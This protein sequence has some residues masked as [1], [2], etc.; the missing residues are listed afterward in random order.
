LKS[1]KTSNLEPAAGGGF[2]ARSPIYRAFKLFFNAPASHPFL[3]LVCVVIAG[4]LEALS[5]GSLVPAVALVGGSNNGSTTP[6]TKILDSMFAAIG[7]EMNIEALIILITGAMLLKSLLTF[8]A[9]GYAAYSK[10]HMLTNLRQ[11]LIRALLSARWSYFADQR[12]GEVASTI[13]TDIIYAGNAYYFAARF[14]A[15]M[16]QTLALIA[17][18]FLVSW[19]VTVLGIALAA[20]LMIGLKF[21]MGK[22]YR[23][24]MKHFQRT[25]GLVALLVDTLNNLKALKAMNRKEPFAALLARRSRSAQK[26]IITQEL[27]KVGLQNSQDALTAILFGGG[28]Y[29]AARQLNI[30]LAELVG[31]GVLVFRIVS[32]VTKS[33][34]VLQITAES[35]GAYWRAFALVD[36]TQAAAEPDSGT[37]V[38]TL[39]SGLALEAV[40]FAHGSNRVLKDF[41]IAIDRGSITVLQGASGVGKTTVIDLIMGLHRPAAGRVTIDGVDLKDI[42]LGAWRSM[43]GYAPQD[44]TLLHASVAENITLGDD[45][46]SEADIWHA[47]KLAGADDFI[48][49]LPL[50]LATDVGEMGA[51][52][53][54]GQRQ[55]IAL[56][57]AVV[58]RPKLLILDEVTSALDPATE[59][60]ICERIARLAPEF[61]VVAITHRPAWTSIATRLYKVAAGRASLVPDERRADPAQRPKPVAMEELS[62]EP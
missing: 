45:K 56:A 2:L 8:S 33:L 1:S 28:L 42:S 20:V 48:R 9:L 14:I 59:R 60:D 49:E 37:N 57:R 26:A 29:F 25:A 23:S 34:N 39:E 24:G 62:H 17:V 52:L 32:S 7:V 13:S 54:G 3:V 27:S 61:T 51:K 31:I 15:G 53:S 21:F 22:S 43:I 4:L 46:I 40:S 12:L 58:A 41:S 18:A 19:K 5:F 11:S 55:R 30:P 16:F 6:I 47:A 36:K 35:E 44:L 38:P 10:A 50:G